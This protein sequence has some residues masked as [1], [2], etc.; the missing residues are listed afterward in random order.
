M[1]QQAAV[2]AV[3][4]SQSKQNFSLDWYSFIC[5]KLIEGFEIYGLAVIGLPPFA[6]RQACQR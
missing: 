6:R 3:S 2:E 4:Q 5:S 1:V